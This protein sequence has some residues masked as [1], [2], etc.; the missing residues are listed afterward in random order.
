MTEEKGQLPDGLKDEYRKLNDLLFN[1]NYPAKI[2]PAKV[3]EVKVILTG[4]GSNL[5]LEV[6]KFLDTARQL[7]INFLGSVRRGKLNNLE[8]TYNRLLAE[9]VLYD[10]VLSYLLMQI[11]LGKTVEIGGR[12]MPIEIGWQLSWA[13]NIFHF[14]SQREIIRSLLQEARTFLN[15]YEAQANNRLS[16]TIALAAL[17]TSFILA[18][19]TLIISIYKPSEP[20]ILWLPPTQT[21]SAK[22][23]KTRGDGHNLY[24][25][26][27]PV[28]SFA[29]VSSLL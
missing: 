16:I 26:V 25:H 9:F 17:I 15:S 10:E 12:E 21:C 18:L 7:K 19:L 2:E 3:E 27:Q 13:I 24:K 22:D 4:R 11:S 20:Q 23:L 6:A 8:Q 28:F 14:S 5:R 1:K 29:R